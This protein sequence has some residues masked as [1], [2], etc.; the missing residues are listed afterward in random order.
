M[1][2]ALSLRKNKVSTPAK[3]IKR[4]EQSEI[5]EKK[6]N[7]DNLSHILQ[8]DPTTKNIEEAKAPVNIEEEK[9]TMNAFEDT[10]QRSK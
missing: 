1:T 9:A 2:L 10:I 8:N 6:A 3:S 5:P 7:L 4:D